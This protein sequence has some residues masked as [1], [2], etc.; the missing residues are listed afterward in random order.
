MIFGLV[1]SLASFIVTGFLEGFT[2]TRLLSPI[3]SQLG[4][5]S[6]NSSTV[7]WRVSAG[8]PDVV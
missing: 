5:G 4:M 3:R 1:M 7:S 2:V 6:H 8:I